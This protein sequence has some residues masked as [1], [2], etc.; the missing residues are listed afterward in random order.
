MP[1][2]RGL[3]PAAPL[4]G[5]DAAVLGAAALART[6]SPRPAHTTGAQP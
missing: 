5:A 4:G 2:L 1:P 6:L 3:R